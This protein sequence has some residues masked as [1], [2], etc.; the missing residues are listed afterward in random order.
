MIWKI[1]LI[2]I[3]VSFGNTIELIVVP[4]IYCEVSMAFLDCICASTCCLASIKKIT[5]PNIKL[6]SADPSIAY[7]EAQLLLHGTWLV[8]KF[9]VTCVKGFFI[10]FNS[11]GIPATQ[12]STQ[13]VLSWSYL[14]S[15]WD[16]EGVKEVS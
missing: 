9:I 16:Q 1:F 5:K 3:K 14:L 11:R 10:Y 15:S 6:D 8:Y 4:R 2:W 12:P 7:L 13:L